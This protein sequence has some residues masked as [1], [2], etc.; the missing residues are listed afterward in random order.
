MTSASDGRDRHDS[1][2]SATVLQGARLDAH[3][4]RVARAFVARVAEH[5]DVT[6][7]ILF[8]S[9]ARQSHRP[10]SDVDI[11]VLLRG[12]RGSFVETKL[13]L[14][15]IAYDVLLDTGVYIQPLPIWDSEWEHPERSP[16][17]TLLETIDR[18]GVRL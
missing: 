4:E 1:G 16:N 2:G 7:A 15:D 8:G 17:P 6:G 18:G 11:A 13:A 10:D 3:I 14:A 9:R 5:Y 12:S